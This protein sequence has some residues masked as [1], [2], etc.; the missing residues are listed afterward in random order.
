MIAVFPMVVGKFRAL[1]KPV[2][3]APAF[4]FSLKSSWEVDDSLFFVRIC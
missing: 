4:S 3:D 2:S 1:K